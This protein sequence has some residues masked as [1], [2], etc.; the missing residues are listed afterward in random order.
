MG[1]AAE[2]LFAF[3]QQLLVRSQQLRYLWKGEITRKPNLAFIFAFEYIWD[4]KRF[5]LYFDL[6]IDNEGHAQPQ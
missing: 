6:E 3:T 4:E 1:V 5:D 2:F